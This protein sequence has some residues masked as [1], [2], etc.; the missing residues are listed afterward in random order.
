[1]DVVISE[2]K[3]Y[4][5]NEIIALYKSVGWTNYLERPERLKEGYKNSLCVLA[6]Y[7]DAEV[8]GILRAV[9]DGATILFIQDI[10]VLP[11]YQRM[12]IGT[13]LITSALKKYEDVY[14]IELLTDNTEKAISFYKSAGLTPANEIG[15]L[16]FI[17]M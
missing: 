9:G 11:K 4:N 15:A 12:G 6:A 13:K 2:Y 14:Q 8:V 16:S 1:M 17:R 7:H 3:E 10:I 5:H